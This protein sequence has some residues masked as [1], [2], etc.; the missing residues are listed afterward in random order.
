[1]GRLIDFLKKNYKAAAAALI[2]VFCIAAAAEIVLIAN[3]P[4]SVA[5][6]TAV[7]DTEAGDVSEAYAE[8]NEE[9]HSQDTPDGENA[10]DEPDET[11]AATEA[12]QDN[13]S[14]AAQSVPEAKPS[15]ENQDGSQQ[16]DA[17]VQQPKSESA[18]L[19]ENKNVCTI[20]ISCATINNNLNQLDKSKKAFVPADGWILKPT[21]VNFED[22]ESVFDVLEKITKQN[23]IQMEFSKTPAYN[24]VYIE[25]INN[26]Y[27]FDCGSLS[28]WQYSVN[29]EF[30]SFGCSLYTLKAGDV[31]EWVYTCDLGRDLGKGM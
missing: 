27:E 11:P 20:S 12:A 30:P 24:S 19:N 14:N 5:V 21:E 17:A 7:T 25:G 3:R 2:C 18:E 29:G 22:G 23:K 4:H 9:T 1:M 16:Q 28:G 10:E 26:L 13:G 31:V 15:S 8:R 6:Q